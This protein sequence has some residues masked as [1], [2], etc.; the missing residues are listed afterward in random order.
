MTAFQKFPVVYK[1]L[2]Q[3]INT[4]KTSEVSKTLEVHQLLKIC[5]AE[6]SNAILDS[7]TYDPKVKPMSVIK[8]KLPFIVI[9]G[10]DGSGKTK[11]STA[12]SE[13][14]KLDRIQTP[15]ASIK[16]L[17]EFFDEQR[18]SIRRAYYSTGNYLAAK[19]VANSKGV[20]GI[21]MDRYWHSTA[22]YAVA[23]KE[24]MPESDSYAELPQDWYHWPN[25]LLK[26]ELVFFLVVSEKVRQYRHRFRNTTNTKEEQALAT[27]NKFR[28]SLLNSYRKVEGVNFM[29]IDAD[30]EIEI[31]I[32][33]V[34]NIL[35][36]KFPA[37]RK[38]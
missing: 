19:D 10:L 18:E 9:E 13:K 36:E 1:S 5:S 27:N 32:K 29:E 38:D 6:S 21:M 35:V 14:L 2:E 37:L 4:L 28:E 8:P 12:L 7:Q 16:F 33:N 25:D 20:N 15:P 23:Q 11:V 24:T 34:L 31:I 3:A 17:K 26:P 22:C 30:P